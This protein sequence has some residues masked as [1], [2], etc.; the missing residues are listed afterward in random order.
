M[1]WTQRQRTVSG[2]SVSGGTRP[3]EPETEVSVSALPSRCA[4]VAQQCSDA[5]EWPL[6]ASGGRR[7]DHRRP[8][9]EGPGLGHSELAAQ[10]PAPVDVGPGPA[11]SLSAPALWAPPRSAGRCT[12]RLHTAGCAC[13]AEQRSE[14]LSVTV[15][16]CRVCL[17]PDRADEHRRGLAALPPATQ[18]AADDQPAA[19]PAANRKCPPIERRVG[20]PSSSRLVD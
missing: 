6:R 10:R 12:V 13:R 1:N 7:A 8:R 5:H 14:R 9:I 15:S 4:A 11:E 16:V 2:V 20:R 17:Q 3:A 18:R 19:Q